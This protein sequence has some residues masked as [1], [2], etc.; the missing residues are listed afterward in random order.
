[1]P[2]PIALCIELVDAPEKERYYKCTARSGR[3][4]GLSIRLD[5]TIGWCED[6]PTACDIWVSADQRLIAK[7]PIDSG[8]VH[9]TRAHRKIL[10]KEDFMATVLNRDE[11][12]IDGRRYRIHVHGVT[13]EVHSPRL[14][15]V[16]RAA[17]AAG[18]AAALTASTLVGCGDKS[19]STTN[20]PS[21][22]ADTDS[23][24]DTDTD[25]DTDT[26]S[27]S[28]T[29]TDVDT[30]T[31]TIF[32]DTDSDDGGPDGGDIDTDDIPPVPII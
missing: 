9:V 10:L 5:G 25:T 18:L 13:E 21:T 7:R 22:A 12:I 32:L 28:D 31:E 11:L 24:S 16:I 1:M 8:D 19:E 3:E 6:G 4:K 14:V 17:R 27:D 26:D 30:E 29:D 2:K 20:P 15:R 23:D